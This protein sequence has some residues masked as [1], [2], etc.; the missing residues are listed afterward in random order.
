[1]LKVDDFYFGQNLCVIDALFFFKDF[2]KFFHENISLLFELV[3]IQQIFSRHIAD[4]L[5]FNASLTLIK[6]S[7]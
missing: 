4:R 2:Q 6:L 3:I 7:C 1:M 5:D